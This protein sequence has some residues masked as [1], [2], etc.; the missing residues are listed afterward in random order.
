MAGA[1]RKVELQVEEDTAEALRDDR[2]RAAVG[3]LV[4]RFVRPGPEDPLLLLLERTAAQAAAAGF[5]DEDLDAELA[6]Y[7]AERRD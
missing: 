3:R 4:D 5:T 7:N 6:E 1:L 2:R